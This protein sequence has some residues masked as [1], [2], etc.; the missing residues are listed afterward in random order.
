M[1]LLVQVSMVMLLSCG[2][3]ERN[4]IYEIESGEYASVQ[5]GLVAA[6]PS[7]P[8]MIRRDVKNNNEEF[9]IYQYR[10]SLGMNKKFSRNNRFPFKHNKYF[11]RTG[12][13]YQKYFRVITKEY[14]AVS[15]PILRPNQAAR[16]GRL[17]FST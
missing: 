10:S 2:D 8:S 1:C 11:N 3:E 7:K 6:F 13:L 15:I 5:G 9:S 12:A 4:D 14:I 17:R 16:Y